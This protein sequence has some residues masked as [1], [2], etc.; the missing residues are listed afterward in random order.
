M[1][2]YVGDPIFTK[3]TDLFFYQFYNIT[4]Q[5]FTGNQIAK[6]Y[7]AQPEKYEDTE[8][9]WRAHFTCLLSPLPIVLR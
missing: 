6:I 1:Y 8:V 3:G 2:T 4:F 5:R 7:K 9:R